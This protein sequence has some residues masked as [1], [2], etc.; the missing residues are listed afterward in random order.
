MPI[1]YRF[2]ELDLR[3]EPPA[4]KLDPQTD[5]RTLN[6]CNLSCFN[7]SCDLTCLC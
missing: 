5:A 4:A 1:E 2:D 6:T 3:E 7:A